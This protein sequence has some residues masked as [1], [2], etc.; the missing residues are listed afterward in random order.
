M[1][2][3]SAS[4]AFVGGFRSCQSLPIRRHSTTRLRM[5]GMKEES[6][7]HVLARDDVPWYR[8]SRMS[9]LVWCNV[10][11]LF[12]KGRYGS[13]EVD[14][15]GR[16]HFNHKAYSR[17]M[18]REAKT[19]EAWRNLIKPATSAPCCCRRSSLSLLSQNMSQH[20]DEITGYPK[21]NHSI[22]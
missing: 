1:L 10:G 22:V 14:S 15:L 5:T 16:M 8:R 7:S 9:E 18:R 2:A 20:V 17:C 6:P 19:T 21:N 3:H 4:L 13:K 12:H 11:G